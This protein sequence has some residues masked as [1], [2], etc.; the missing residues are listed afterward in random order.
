MTVFFLEGFYRDSTSDGGQVVGTVG[1]FVQRLCTRKR[2]R[3]R[4]SACVRE[5]RLTR[6]G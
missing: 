1:V 5:E 4:E 6:R 3:E 2:E